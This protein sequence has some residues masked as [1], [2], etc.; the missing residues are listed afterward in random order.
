MGLTDSRPEP[1]PVIK[2]RG[3]KFREDVL[4]KLSHPNQTF[5]DDAMEYFAYKTSQVKQKQ[6]DMFYIELEVCDF[7]KWTDQ[8]EVSI[9][10]SKKLQEYDISL[11]KCEIKHIHDNYIVCIDFQFL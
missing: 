8:A 3:E 2:S 1:E 7:Y 5:V 4:D 11:V 9:L 10:L 6:Y